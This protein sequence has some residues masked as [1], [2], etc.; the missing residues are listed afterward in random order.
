M[1]DTALTCL[2][3]ASKVEETVKKCRD[4]IVACKSVTAPGSQFDGDDESEVGLLEFVAC[5]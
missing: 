1:Q 3:V 4:L 2:F 5:F